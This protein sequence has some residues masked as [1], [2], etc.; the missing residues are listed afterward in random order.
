[1]G[2]AQCLAVVL[3]VLFT[4]CFAVANNAPKLWIKSAER[5][6]GKT[7]LLE[8]LR[9]L[10]ERALTT[11]YISAAMLPRVVDQYHPTLLMDEIDTFLT[12]SEEM[13]GVLN[14]GFDRESYVI[15]GTK[16]GDDW[17]PRK[18]SA[19]CPQA[20]AGI[21]ELP[22]TIADR[23]LCIELQRKP[24]R[25]KVTR[26]R[27]RDS[28]PL[29]ELAQ[30]CAR[31]AADNIDELADAEPA[32][33]EALNDRASDSW[34]LCI[35]IADRIGEEAGERA[36]RAALKIS[37][38]GVAISS[39]GEQLLSDVR[40]IFESMRPIP[41]HEQKISS[42]DLVL[43][44]RELIHRPWPDL[45][46]GTPL[47]QATLA[48]LLKPF[49]ITPGQVWI[50]GA[51]IRGYARTAFNDAFERYL[52]PLK[53][54][55]DKF[56]SHTPRDNAKKAAR[57]LGDEEFRGFEAEIGALGET[58]PSTLKSNENPSETASPSGLTPANGLDEEV[59]K[60]NSAEPQISSISPAR[61]QPNGLDA[62]SS[63]K[64]RSKVEEQ[65]L[66]LWREHPDWSFHKL[67]RE[68]AVT[69]KRVQ[70]VITQAIAE[71]RAP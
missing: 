37:G 20:L 54:G 35:A 10:A 65:I 43:R 39:I 21:G 62:S 63:R 70:R 28:G 61:S 5:R 18:F 49:H 59:A 56:L 40:D 22:D 12:G 31:W 71:E 58:G 47:T 50:K 19:W 42:S 26:L 29:E 25:Q 4:Y 17:V 24:R 38:D 16:V 3:W 44:L 67:G 30:R 46:N 57:P 27:R 36:R 41:A 14:S 2:D 55:P 48:R 11:N 8:V 66:Q 23:S 53:P 52:P 32:M 34:E 45:G 9:H 68:C 60:E 51:N 1:M 13:R 33:P 6:A 64:P 69:H 7:R 15:I